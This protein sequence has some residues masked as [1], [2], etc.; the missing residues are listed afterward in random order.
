MNKYLIKTSLIILIFLNL[1]CSY[2]PIFSQKN[3]NFEI[4]EILFSGEK[5][6]NRIIENKLNLIKNTSNVNKIKY[7]IV[8]HTKINKKIISKDSKGDPSKFELL[9]ITTFEVTGNQ[10]VLVNKELKNNNIYNNISD[11]FELEQTEKNI[12]ENIAEIISD[13]ILSSIINLDDN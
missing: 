3:Y 6:I 4:N 11:K 13:E 10:K 8:I 5:E 12:L 2:N 7:N 9:V 1:A